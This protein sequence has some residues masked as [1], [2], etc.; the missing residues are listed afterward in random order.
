MHRYPADMELQKPENSIIPYIEY[1]LFHQLLLRHLCSVST[2]KYQSPTTFVFATQFI[3]IC[4]KQTQNFQNKPKLKQMCTKT[5]DLSIPL[6][7]GEIVLKGFNK[8]NASCY[9]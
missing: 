2:Q 3:F 5:A 8:K 4:F 9:A 6:I 7:P 1:L